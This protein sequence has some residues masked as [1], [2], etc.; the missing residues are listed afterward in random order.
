MNFFSLL[1]RHKTWIISKNESVEILI[2]YYYRLTVSIPIKNISSQ[3]FSIGSWSP[4][5]TSTPVFLRSNPA[6]LIN[7]SVTGYIHI[8][9]YSFC[10]IIIISLCMLCNLIEI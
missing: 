1:K 8:L 3:L 5:L 10:S 6:I 9:C 7:F 4:C 2:N